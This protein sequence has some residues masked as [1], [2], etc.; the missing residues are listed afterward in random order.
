LRL[1]PRTRR[2]LAAALL[3]CAFLGGARAQTRG[4]DGAAGRSQSA[5]KQDAQKQAAQKKLDA[6]AAR[7]ARGVRE[8]VAA[9]REVADDARSFDDLYESTRLQSEAADALWPYDEQGARAVLRR[10][11]EAANA[12]GAEDK[13]QGFGTSEDPREDARNTLTSARRSIITAALKHDPRMA[14]TFMREFERGLRADESS[15]PGQ[16]GQP[17]AQ[18]GEQAKDSSPSARGRHDLS[19]YDWQLINIARQLSDEGEFKGAAEVVA[20]LV[21]GGPSPPLVSFILALRRRDA[22]DAD[23]LYLRLLE[24]TRADAGADANDVLTLSTPVVSPDLY[25]VVNEDG[26]AAFTPRYHRSGDEPSAA[27]PFPAELRAAFFNAAASVLLRPRAPRGV[28]QPGDDSAALYFAVGRLLPFFERE[29]PQ[30]AAALHARMAALASEMDAARRDALAAK[31]DLSSLTPRNFSD[32][33]A[34]WTDAISGARDAAGRDDARLRALFVAVDKRLWDRARGVAEEIEDLEERSAARLAIA[35]HQVLD[36]GRAYADDEEADDLARAA[37]FVRAA[38][39]PPEV[40]AAGLAQAA[41]L[42]ARRG[43]RARAGELLAEAAASAAQADRGQQCVAALA[44]VTL[45]ASRSDAGRVW[46]SLPSLVRAANDVDELQ[47]GAV[48]FRFA[49]GPKKFEFGVP[50]PALSLP[51]VFA[52]AARLDAVRAL[53]GARALKDEVLRAYAT[54][55]AARAALEKS[56]RAGVAVAR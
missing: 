27:Q 28:G 38:D 13:A 40:R 8:A 45:S 23:A 4:G 11:W 52:A 9:L 47:W 46:E 50:T 18:T 43:K 1:Q 21:A 44:L 19:P 31:M 10:A 7:K 15:A 56:S 55:A 17:A 54:L 29:A 3:A 26:S 41:E 16:N 2:T 51:D 36:I 22:R 37:A 12:P 53:A 49:L 30:L 32:P 48:N 25:V 24:R 20:P 33:L 34:Y 35:I 5:S 42:A 39:V 6:D 14:D